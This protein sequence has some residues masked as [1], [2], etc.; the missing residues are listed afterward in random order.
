MEFDAVDVGSREILLESQDLSLR[1]PGELAIDPLP[2]LKQDL[3]EEASATGSRVD[4]VVVRS[5][6]EHGDREPRQL[7]H[8][9]VLTESPPEDRGEELL[10]RL[11]DAVHVCP[12]EGEVFEDADDLHDL[13][14]RQQDA[15][16]GREDRRV[17][18]TTL[19]E[20]GMDP[21]RDRGGRLASPDLKL[22]LLPVRRGP[23][24]DYLG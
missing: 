12:G 4:R 22:P 9:E 14:V 19:E 20:Q 1:A 23:L 17:R 8:R 18:P 24:V 3:Q 6:F 10:E 21:V 15:D 13:R 11:P 2:T 7:T 16:V 5:D